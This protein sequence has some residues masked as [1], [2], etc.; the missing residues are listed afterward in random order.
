M[1]LTKLVKEHKT[2]FFIGFIILCFVSIAIPILLFTYNFWNQKMSST[3]S[4]WGTFGDFMGG[5][6]NTLVSL[7]S[8]IVLGYLTYLVGKQSNEANK[9]NNL[10]LRRLEAFNELSDFMPKMDFQIKET[11]KCVNI[12]N[13]N[14]KNNFLSIEKEE[15]YKNIISTQCSN[16]SKF[17]SYISYFDVK[18]KHIFNYNFK[19]NDFKELKESAQKNDE[20]Y[21]QIQIFIDSNTKNGENLDLSEMEVF[22]RLLSTFLKEISKELN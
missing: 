14:L 8:L 13:E 4:D 9:E 10:L 2:K 22:L 21:Q 6:I 17:F 12:L 5:T 15:N 18:Y 3:I 1:Q 16:L 11:S 20:D 19:S 7:I